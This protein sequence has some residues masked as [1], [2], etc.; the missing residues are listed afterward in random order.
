[1]SQHS[2]TGFRVPSLQKSGERGT[3]R[4]EVW[5]P[6]PIRPVRGL[7][8]AWSG[9]SRRSR[10]EWRMRGL[11]Q[12]SAFIPR[13]TLESEVSWQVFKSWLYNPLS[14]SGRLLISTVMSLKAEL[15]RDGNIRLQY[16]ES[17]TPLPMSG[18]IP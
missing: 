10:G 5:R 2:L 3:A 12:S 11:A 15:R 18:F 17:S 6:E 7:A 1:M 4:T 16:L 14:L 13:E 8:R 9:Y